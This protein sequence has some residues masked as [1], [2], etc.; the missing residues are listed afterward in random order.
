MV[1]IVRLACPDARACLRS[2]CPPARSATL[3]LVASGVWV[4]AAASTQMNTAAFMTVRN[5]SAA[6]VTIVSV[7]TPAAGVAELHE[8]RDEDGVMRMRK[9]PGITIPAHGTLT[10][11]PGGLHIMLFRLVAPLAPGST[12]PLVLSAADGRAIA[13]TADVRSLE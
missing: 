1:Q 11:R 8:M 4:R 7:T 2:W 5:T 10:L 9:V 6:D 3:P 12:V 13:L